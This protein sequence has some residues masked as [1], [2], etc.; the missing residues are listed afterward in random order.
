MSTAF[1]K[2]YQVCT[3]KSILLCNHAW[4]AAAESGVS[5]KP[6]LRSRSMAAL[7]YLT[8]N[9]SYSLLMISPVSKSPPLVWMSRSKKTPSGRRLCD[10]KL[11]IIRFSFGPGCAGTAP[12][13]RRYFLRNSCCFPCEHRLVRPVEQT[14]NGQ[15]AE[16]HEPPPAICKELQF[17]TI[18]G[19]LLRHRTNEIYRHIVKIWLSV[20]KN[21]RVCSWKENKDKWNHF[22]SGAHHWHTTCVRWVS[23]RCRKQTH[24]IPQRLYGFMIFFPWQVTVSFSRFFLPNTKCWF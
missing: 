21:T 5:E 24:W 14:E 19:T 8:R 1:K 2:W 17:L 18:N 20:T 15:E 23:L 22:V 9:C 11:L 12:V 4:L 13:T 7:S 10:T 16:H 6:E 3:R